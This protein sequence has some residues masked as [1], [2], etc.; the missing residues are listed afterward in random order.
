MR[1][2]PLLFLFCL[3]S[4]T[5]YAQADTTLQPR[6]DSFLKLNHLLDIERI[7]DFT[8][9][10]LFTIVPREQMAEVMKN[11]FDNREIKVVLDSLKLGKIYPPLTTGEGSFVK[12]DYS[13]IMRMHFTDMDDDSAD[14]SEKAGFIVGILENKYGTGNAS[15]DPLKKTFDIRVHTSL[16]AIRDSHSPQWTFINFDKE[17]P[18]TSLLL[19][20]ELIDTLSS[21]Q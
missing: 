19:S 3:F 20:H 8:Y 5:G 7:L 10:K 6:L 16:V 14:Y 12:V 11:T 2:L 13:M 1:R 17:E 9:P 15:F 18:L 4:G 21:Q